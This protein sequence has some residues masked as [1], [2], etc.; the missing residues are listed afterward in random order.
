MIRHFILRGIERGR[1]ALVV[2][3]LPVSGLIVRDAEQP[4]S[5]VFLR[6]AAGHMAVE[7]KKRVLR[8]VLRFVGR[9]PQANQITDE[10]LTQFFKQF[11]GLRSA[12]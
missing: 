9:K 5:D 6:S 2:A 1:E 3:G 4:A 10:W 11:R 7:L 12:G 8:N